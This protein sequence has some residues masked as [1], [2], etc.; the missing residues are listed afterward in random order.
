MTV[1]LPLY[2]SGVVMPLMCAWAV[3]DDPKRLERLGEL[4]QIYE[5]SAGSPCM[6]RG[7]VWLKKYLAKLREESVA[8]AMGDDDAATR[9]YEAQR[10]FAGFEAENVASRCVIL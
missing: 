8:L 1:F 3:E 5:A 7:G 4:L 10:S 9:A 2:A 6:A